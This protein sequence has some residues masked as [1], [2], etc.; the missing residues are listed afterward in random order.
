MKLNFSILFSIVFTVCSSQSNTEIFLYDIEVN[1]SKIQ[2]K[3]G[4]NLSNNEGYDNQPSFLDDNTILFASTRNGQT[5]IAKYNLQSELKTF[6][7]ATEGS[8]YT[9]L[10]IPNQDAVSAVRL[11]K[12][13]LQRLYRYSL[14]DGKSSELIKDLV[15]AYYVWYNADIVV[16]AVI[17][18]EQL[19]LYSTNI[20][21]ATNK[22]LATNIGRSLHKIPNSN[23][24]SFISKTNTK[25]WQ[26]KS[27]NPLTGKT[28]LIANTI[29]GSSDICWLNE[30]NLLSGNKTVL[31]KLTLQKDYNWKKVKNLTDDGIVNITRLATNVKGTKLLITGDLATNSNSSNMM[32][33]N[34]QISEAE[35]S[36]I[37]DKHIDPFNK[38]NL[39]EFSNAFNINIIVKKFP[40][41]IMY[42]GRDKL[43]EN[44]KLFFENNEKSNVKVLN[45]I[46]LRNVVIDEELITINNTTKR[47]VT[48]YETGVNGINTM[49]FIANSKTKK[50]TEAIIN[51]KLEN[52]NKKDVKAFG[53]N[54]STNAKIYDFPN[55]IA[56]DGRSELRVKYISLLE[57]TPNL[58]AEIVNRIIIGNKVIDK[59]KMT[60]NDKTVYTIAIYEVN[61]SLITRVTMIQ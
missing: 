30:R 49:T 31:Y 21:K 59:E 15:V 8:E 16:S 55:E 52:Y 22:K 61:N 42:Y 48:I 17:E 50:N 11:D 47:Q 60:I 29:K 19:N 58:Y 26:I 34:Q 27:L 18:G 23:L 37:V 33:N 7:N 13:G 5:D 40:A 2:I 36:L 45:R 54:Y 39:T 3:N 41:E 14:S 12:D 53:R 44:Y 20:K 25:Q 32:D 51:E 6:I 10:K 9:P 57:N 1:Q 35:A 46:T 43:K 38:R 4:Q 24:I 56:L 28:K